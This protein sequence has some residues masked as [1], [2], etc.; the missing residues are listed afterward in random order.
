M[1]A[2]ETT[3]LL[4]EESAGQVNRKKKGRF[5]PLFVIKFKHYSC[6]ESLYPPLPKNFSSQFAEKN[7][8]LVSRRTL[9]SAVAVFAKKF[10]LVVD[11]SLV[12]LPVT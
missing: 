4:S 5:L 2:K 3:E 10:Y 8:Q 11:F 7:S 6:P 1:S 9:F 12:H